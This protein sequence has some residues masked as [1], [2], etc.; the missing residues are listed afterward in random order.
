VKET[1]SDAAAVHAQVA[2]PDVA[3]VAQFYIPATSSLAERRPRTLK[4]NDTFALFDHYGDILSGPGSPEGIFHKDTR[5]LSRLTLAIEGRRPLLLSSTVQNN[6]AVLDVDLTNPDVFA[7]ERLILPKDTLHIARAKF[8]WQAC[9]HELLSLRN[10]GAERREFHL[11]LEFG[12]D[13]A[14][15]FEVRGFRRQRRGRIDARVIDGC[16]VEFVYAALDRVERSTRIRFDPAPRT[17]T[18][19]NAGF[20]VALDSR[21]RRAIFVQVTCDD[22]TDAPR[23]DVRFFTAMRKVRG[24]LRRTSRR[25]AG[26]ETSNSLFNE[27]LCRGMSDLTMLNTD[28]AQGPYPYAGIPWF[29]TAFGR[30]AIITAI[31]MLW[32]EPAIARGV[33]SYLAAHQAQAED[34]F[35]DAEPGKILHETRNGE[36][37]HLREV[38]FGRYYGSVDSTPLFVALAGLYW[39]RSRDRAA[40]ERIWPAVKNALTWMERYG[41]RNGDGFVSYG[42]RQQSGLRNQGWKDSEDSVFHADG[43]LAEPPIALAEVQGYVYLARR[44]AARMARD[45]GEQALGSRLEMEARTLRERFEDRFW[46]EEIGFYALALDGLGQP[47]CV[48]ASNGGQLLFTGIAS[49][50]RAAKLVEALFER[51]FFS[52]WGI[53]TLSAREVRYNPMSYHNG[54]VWPH[55]NALIALGLARYG[56]TTQVMQL[57]TALFNAAALMDLRRLPELFCGFGRE[58]GRTPTLYPVACAPQAWSAATPFALL[59]ACLG[60]EFDH[61]AAVI[62]LR[63]PHLPEFLDWMRVR[64]L[65]MADTRVELMVQRHRGEVAVSLL[66]RDGPAELQVIL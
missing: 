61:A 40:M 47:C 41:D 8:L 44:L 29:S 4:H 56:W 17:L 42:R 59:Q 23:E 14:D 22:R 10:F 9:C 2:A 58:P 50:Q 15:L 35:A 38:P 27:V 13:F 25:A 36:L 7:G 24:D 3:P 64:N 31:Q 19:G 21:Q 16:T 65:R 26:I 46:C 52:G 63:R 66:E 12:V 57:S 30:D 11:S 49:R 60:L 33:L 53:R 37:A 48:R 18:T 45:L 28:T 34:A 5:A 62:R 20:D 39:L 6:N 55:D 54:S 1:I 32:V 43:R 51:D